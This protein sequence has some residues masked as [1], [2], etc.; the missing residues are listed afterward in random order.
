MKLRMLG[1]SVVVSSLVACSGGDKPAAEGGKPGGGE[2]IVNVIN[3]PR[4]MMGG[5]ENSIEA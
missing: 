5:G 3:W 1:L 4:L 2:K